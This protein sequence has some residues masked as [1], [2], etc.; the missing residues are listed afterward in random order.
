MS[1]SSETSGARLAA[2]GGAVFAI[3]YAAGFVLHGLASGS[4]NDETR[5][6]VVA[7]Y[8]DEGN[9]ALV[10]L[11]GLLIGF[12]LVFLLLFLGRLRAALRRVEGGGA[13]L[14]TAALVAAGVIAGLGSWHVANALILLG[15]LSL[16]VAVGIAIL[17]HRLYDIDLLINRTLVYG[18]LTV[19]VVTIYVLVVGGLAA[20]FHESADLWVALVATGL[21]ALLVQPLRSTLQRRV[22]R[23]MY[24]EEGRAPG[25]LRSRLHE[26]FVPEAAELQRAHR[27]LVAAREEE[28]R[29]L[30]RDLHDGLGPALAGA[31]LKFEAAENLLASDPAAA[32]AL[33]EDS[34]TEIQHA[35][36][37][38]RRLVYALRPPALDELGL[39][40]A[41]REQAEKL[42][43]AK[44]PRIEIEAPEPLPP[45][46]AAV[47]VAVYRISLEAMTNAA[48]HA[49]AQ[50]CVVRIALNGD[51]ELEV[52][53]D[54]RGLPHDLHA[55]V[56]TSSMRERAEELGGS[57]Q[58]EPLDGRGTRVVARLPLSS[59]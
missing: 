37:D 36:A 6:E 53:D 9:E 32:R 23:L 58:I 20:L 28:R 5:A 25:G 34:R 39:V 16:P 3:L 49:D 50:R 24:G 27:R 29:R 51:L 42:G 13:A 33:L 12:A 4:S 52:A 41:L 46:P 45:L 56:G 22:N 44:R 57:C 26:A 8:G 55:G 11:G 19:G 21:V 47:E 43:A 59:A 48:R 30:R 18:G 35:V 17:R 54:G 40:K 38:V 14:S 7:R 31:A 1:A 15:V 2:P 10:H